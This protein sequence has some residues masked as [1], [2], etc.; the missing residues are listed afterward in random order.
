M[1][2][3]LILHLLLVNNLFSGC[4]F[5]ESNR[6]KSN[7]NQDSAFFIQDGLNEVKVPEN[8]VDLSQ[9]EISKDSLDLRLIELIESP[10]D[11][12]EKLLIKNIENL[13]QRGAKPN[14]MIKVTYSVR[15]VGTYL[16]II[17]H[18]YQDKYN[19]YTAITSPMHAAVGSGN[20]K[21]VEKLIAHGGNVN[22]VNPDKVYLIDLALK[23]D[24]KE[25]IDLLLK[26]GCIASNANL[27]MSQNI[28]VIERLV[29][30][31]ARPNTID[32]NFALADK[33][34]LKRLLALRPPMD[35]LKLDMSL[36]MKDD[37]LLDLLM[38]NGMTIQ[39]QGKFPDECPI[40][41]SAVKYG[42]M[43]AL[44]KLIT[45]GASIHEKCKN[46]F[47]E[48]PLQ[49]AVHYSQTDILIYLLDLKANPNEKD[50]TGKSVLMQACNTDND[51][52]INIL[53]DRGANME[54]NGYFHSTPLMF[55]VQNKNY[56]SAETLIKRKANVNYKSKYGETAL[57]KAVENNDYP[58]IK[59]LVDN[60][61]NPKV[62]YNSKNL[63]QFAEEQEAAP[64]VV[65]YLKKLIE[66]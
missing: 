58:M 29:S 48:T 54:Y 41:Y 20:T 44:K 1:K 49:I 52:I 3:L 59:L 12:P 47:G 55:A 2:Y 65:A 35:N 63:V 62:I 61:A 45:K 17:K 5:P 23:I 43:N 33:N 27:S 22:L 4:I 7:R 53:I 30:L 36:L 10:G 18:F 16:P 24:N 34:E 8:T 11:M 57:V 21:V 50:W 32:I 37:E 9:V 28:S 60:G 15:K 38:E 39:A 64:A 51:Q 25:M 42:N 56:I 19:E 31:G 40:I 13:I 26:N 46:G 66:N 6:N 14:A